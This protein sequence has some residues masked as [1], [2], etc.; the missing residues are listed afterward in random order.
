MPNNCSGVL[1]TPREVIPRCCPVS[2][3]RWPMR[4]TYIFLFLLVP[5]TVHAG[6]L[7]ELSANPYGLDSTTNPVGAGN[8]Y[9]PNS[10]TNELGHYVNPYSSTSATNPYATDAPG[11][12]TSRKT[13]GASPVP[14]NTI[15]IRPAIPSA[16]S[17]RRSRAN[18]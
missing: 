2:P 1:G 9:D 14:I 5:F 10:V 17:D 15:R 4:C 11:S 18:R 8:P 7:G 16:A 13:S 12:T 3:T 6:Y